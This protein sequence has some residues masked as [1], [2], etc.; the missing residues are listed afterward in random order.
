MTLRRRDGTYILRLSLSLVTQSPSID[1]QID[2][3][4][5]AQTK[6]ALDP[7]SSTTVKSPS[8]NKPDVPQ[9]TYLTAPHPISPGNILLHNFPSP[10]EENSL[11]SIT[12]TLAT[13]SYGVIGALT[14]IWSFVAFKNGLWAFF[15]RSTM[16]GGL[17]VAVYVSHGSIGRKLEKELDRIRLNMGKER[18]ETFS[19]PTPE[20]VE[21]MNAFTKVV[22]PL[23]NPEMFISVVD[24][25]EVRSDLSLF[26]IN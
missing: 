5:K 22:W 19:P 6:A 1:Y 20:S 3:A 7:S 18:G 8:S 2:G 25:I 17:A 4:T 9:D 10:V 24:M 23:I 11:A 13:Y 14:V 12:S 21:W 15:V 26:S 16:I